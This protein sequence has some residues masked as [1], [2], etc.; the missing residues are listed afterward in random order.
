MYF[1]RQIIARGPRVLRV[2]A[3][4]GLMALSN[5]AFA[6]ASRTWVSGVGD[7]AN[8]CSRTAPCKTFAGA[9]SKTAA[10]GEI[11][12]LDPGGFG[13][14]TITKSITIDGS[15]MGGILASL[16]NGVVVNAGAGDVVRLRNLSINGFGNGLAG[17]RFLA[18]KALHVENSQ[19]YGFTGFGIDFQPAAGSQ[20]FLS[21]VKISGNNGASGGGVQVAPGASG[22]AV[23]SIDNTRLENNTVG[24]QV[25]NRGI[26]SIRHS[27]VSGN[28][29]M[30]VYALST[31]DLAEITVQECLI[32]NNAAGAG[33]A[34]GLWASGPM[35]IVR[36]SDNVVTNNEY[37]MHAGSGGQLISFG[38]NKVID[39]TIDGTPNSTVL[40]K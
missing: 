19:I 4:I 8:P 13:T 30:G 34:G 38:D 7:D 24:L 20:L 37:G 15:N 28:S 22:A 31:T 40:A 36:I 18:G 27:V 6:Q 14:V 35:A 1:K 21:D 26:A 2:L 16:V 10:N 5:A 33:A 25:K 32:A 39:N 12:V 17:V 29:G 23:V 3:C 9:I 11:D